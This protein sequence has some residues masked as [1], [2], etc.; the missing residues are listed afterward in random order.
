MA[1]KQGNSPESSGQ[2]VSITIGNQQDVAFEA[3]SAMNVEAQV[4]EYR[5]GN[6]PVFYPIKMPGL[7]RVGNIALRNAV[8]ND[9]SG[10][11]EWHAAYESGMIKPIKVVISV[12]DGDG[13]AILAWTLH[14]AW[15]TK[16][17]G[18]D[19]EGN[20]EAVEVELL[21]FACESITVSAGKA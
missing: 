8:L 5:H 9:S 1:D 15:P 6:S 21:E 17:T 3:I 10:F 7:G 18:A 12:F 11:R 16:I 4:I 19:L 13:L 20:K 14:N 2:K